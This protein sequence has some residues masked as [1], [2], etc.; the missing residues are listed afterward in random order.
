MTIHGEE[1]AARS[2]P[3]IIPGDGSFIREVAPG[4]A[5][6]VPCPVCGDSDEPGWLAGF[7]PPV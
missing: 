4:Q 3:V 5:V 7:Q 1:S 2:R 6:T